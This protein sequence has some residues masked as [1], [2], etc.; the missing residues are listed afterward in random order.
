MSFRQL[1]SVKAAKKFNCVGPRT[2][3]KKLL[4]NRDLD[5]LAAKPASP[6]KADF[7]Y[8]SSPVRKRDERSKLPAFDCADCK[9]YYAGA[10]LTDEQE[11]IL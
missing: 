9:K 11:P 8:V 7:K 3:L 2:P 5:R 1:P 6:S 10:D 4:E